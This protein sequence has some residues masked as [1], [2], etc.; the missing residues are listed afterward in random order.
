MLG[1]AGPVNCKTNL[2]GMQMEHHIPHDWSQEHHETGSSSQQNISWKA[3][4]IDSQARTNLGARNFE[5]RQNPCKKGDKEFKNI[6]LELL[7]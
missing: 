1:A 6:F 5:T 4:K 7:R 3:L 2:A